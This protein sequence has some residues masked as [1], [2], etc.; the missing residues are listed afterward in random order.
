MLDD[1]VR[2]YL[3]KLR[4]TSGNTSGLI[5]IYHK[6]SKDTFSLKTACIK[7]DELK[8]KIEILW[9]NK[10]LENIYSGKGI[11]IDVDGSFQNKVTSYALIIRKNGKVIKQISGIVDE[12]DVQGS[13]Q[14]AG[15]LEAAKEAVIFC[16]QN[17]ID[18]VTIYYDMKG[19]EMWAKGRWKTNKNITRNF[20][21]FIKDNPLDIKWFKV[22]S[23]VGHRWN[24]AV[25]KLAKWAID[26]YLM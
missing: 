26:K 6:P 13:H 1:T 16:K 19:I 14:V 10:P 4:I 8:K 21:D 17:N 20:A 5:S 24:E 9:G 22:E 25:D 23:H 7:D 11:E 2:D 15:E 18:K 12:T 3:I